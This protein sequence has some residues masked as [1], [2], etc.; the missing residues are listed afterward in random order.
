MTGLYQ[1]TLDCL[2]ASD[3]DAKLAAVYQLWADCQAARLPDDAD[4]VPVQAIAD[5]G[6]P[7]KPPLVPVNSLKQRS[8]GQVAGRAAMLH[9]IAHIEFSAINLALDA[10]Y[11][12]RGLPADYYLDWL[13]VAQEE[14]QHFELVRQR[15]RQLGFD[16]G[17]FPAH[18]ALWE[19]ACRSADDV[20]DRMALVP[21]LQEARGLDVTPPIMDKFR[22]V[23]DRDSL[24]ALEVILRDEVGHVALGDKWF[25]HLCQERGLEPEAT[26]RQRLA[27]HGLP[28]PQTPMN[29]AARLQAGFSQEELAGFGQKR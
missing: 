13:G 26:F 23:G 7:A 19:L 3:T 12:F 20:L 10:A 14:C 2:M 8:M 17:D 27:S 24:A 4:L 22:S 29:V 28:L 11:R 9:A 1:A 25:R 16:Y 18:G 21:R 15:L 5:A 6:R